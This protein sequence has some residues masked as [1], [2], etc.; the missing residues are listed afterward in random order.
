MR[1]NPIQSE[2]VTKIDL[3]AR[4]TAAI[5]NQS[6]VNKQF[7]RLRFY[8]T[9]LI[10]D[11]AA[12]LV[13]FLLA[14]LPHKLSWTASGANLA[15]LIIPLYC[16]FAFNNQ[17]YAHPALRSLSYSLEK[18]LLALGAT[19]L[20]IFTVAFLLKAPLAVPRAAFG[21]G[22]VAS[23]LL[24]AV[25]RMLILRH[26]RRAYPNG[27]TSE[28]VIV[29]NMDDATPALRSGVEVVYARQAGIEPDLNDPRMLNRLGIVLRSHDRVIVHC[30][31]DRHADWALLLK[32]SNVIG[33]IIIPG[34]GDV[35]VVGV[36]AFNGND[37]LVVARGPLNLANRA[38]KRALDIV[39]TVPVLIALS[40]L[41]LLV[42][43]AIKMDTPG[44]VFFRQDRVGRGNRIFKILKFRSMR[45]ERT[46]GAGARS[47]SLDDDRIT[48]V[49]RIIRRTSI[50]ELPQLLNVL[51]GDMS[52][53]GPRPHALGS[54]AGNRLFWEI[55]RQYWHRHALKPGI[56]GLAQVR[57]F[58]GA[59]VRDIDLRNRLE[60][61]LEYLNGW[62]L[63]RD[64]AILIGTV[65][66]L[67]HKNAY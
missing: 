38:K 67:V 2:R 41:M 5:A 47:A 14:S 61:D 31:A 51:L 26:V 54:L 10:A 34:F 16:L 50:D 40:P 44:P 4:A 64:I 37:T 22:I 46:D 45:T 56:T 53:V 19:V 30:P 48:R 58:R 20:A 24:I 13:G 11:A 65:Q 27:L 63:W 57:G 28:L 60:A 21:F 7:L 32:G 62:T 36:G 23:A 18:S 9:L 49:G 25:Q 33:E 42:A 12:I 39:L 59:T 43:L 55:D 3:T 35:G 29:D 8:A 66:V 15:M 52:L 17:A 1:F 6:S